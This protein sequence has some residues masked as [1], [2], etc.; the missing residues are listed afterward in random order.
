MSEMPVSVVSRGV[1]T[2]DPTKNLVIGSELHFKP[3]PV[4]GEVPEGAAKLK[5]WQFFDGMVVHIGFTDEEFERI[6]G[7]GVIVAPGTAL[8]A[9]HVIEPHMD[10]IMAKTAVV[11]CYGI[12][13]HGLQIWI[14]RKVTF[15]PK[16]DITILGIELASALPP[17]NTFRQS[18]ITTRTPSVGERLTICGFRAGE[19]AFQRDENSVQVSGAMWVCKGS[20]V[21]AYPLGRDRM[22]PWPVLAV[23]VNSQGGMSGGPVYD[24]NGLLVGLLC[25]GD[26][27]T[28][29]VSL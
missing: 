21:D 9:T 3:T 29:Y 5:N 24:H 10:R 6:E 7:S 2:D 28:S 18:V 8:C 11:T 14:V 22:I 16:T 12:A 13:S 4:A 20:I 26:E 15:V 1:V 19:L 25:S 27:A 17:R 23:E